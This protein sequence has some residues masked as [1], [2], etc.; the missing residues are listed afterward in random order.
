MKNLKGKAKLMAMALTSFVYAMSSN[1][2]ACATEAVDKEIVNTEDFLNKDLYVK[3][4]EDINIYD[5][6]NKDNIIGSLEEGDKLLFN[7]LWDEGYYEVEYNNSL[8]Y[9]ECNKTD[10]ISEYSFDNMV[11]IINDTTMYRDNDTN[12]ELEKQSI[13]KLFANIGSWSLVEVDG[14]IGYVNTLDTEVLTNTF[15]VVDISDLSL[16]L[17]QNGEIILESPV[18]TGKDSSP[19]DLGDFNVYQ[20]CLDYTMRGENNSY[21]SFAKYVTKYNE[22]SNE[23]IHD[24]SWR[25]EAEFNNRK[26]IRSNKGSHGCVNAP[27]DTAK[28]VYECCNVGDRVIIRK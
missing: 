6:V 11:E 2:E 22:N 10:L 20:K 18:I 25:S 24:A 21:T 14:N 15:V 27:L 17:Y 12:I 19:T 5:N 9:L 28:K 13:G 16:T 4:L 8:G 26:L 7:C 3:A 1:V 23:Y